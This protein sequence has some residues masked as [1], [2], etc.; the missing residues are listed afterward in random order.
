MTRFDVLNKY[1]LHESVDDMVDYLFSS[2]NLEACFM[3]K[4]LSDCQTDNYVSQDVCREGV[5]QYL[6]EELEGRTPQKARML[7]HGGVILPIVSINHDAHLVTVHDTENKQ[8]IRTDF[9]SVA[10]Q[11]DGMT[12]EEIAAFRKKAGGK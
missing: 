10:F 4:K 12:K 6:L 5:R 2:V 9:D 3:C 11:Y 8:I 7:L 1:Q